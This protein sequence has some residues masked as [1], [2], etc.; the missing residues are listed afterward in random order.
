MSTLENIDL[1]IQVQLSHT[2][3]DG[4]ATLFIGFNMERGIF[5]NHLTQGDTHFL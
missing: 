1:D 3:K 5:L 2:F 4:L